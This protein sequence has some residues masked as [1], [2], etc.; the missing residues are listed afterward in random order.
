MSE[1]TTIDDIAR[2][3]NISKT[4]VSRAI[5]GKGRIG[6]ATRERVLAYIEEHNYRPSAIAKSLASSKT[7]NLAFAMPAASDFVDLPFFQKCMWGIS[8]TASEA[9]YDVLLCMVNESDISG[10]ERLASNHKVDGVILGRTYENGLA[11]QF[12]TE[13]GIPFVT[14][15]MSAFEGAVQVDNHHRKGCRELT[16]YLIKSG[17]NKIALI[18]GHEG[19]MVDRNRCRGFKDAF[20]MNGRPFRDDLFFNYVCEGKSV[21]KTVGAILDTDCECIVCMDD[22][23]CNLVVKSLA[24]RGASVPG[25]I[26]LASFYNSPVLSGGRPAV[27]ALDFDAEAIGR[28]SC[29]ILLDCIDGREV[30]PCTLLGYEMLIRESTCS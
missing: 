10:L 26:G 11:E 5:S 17:Y 6:A 23:V 1:R 3:L 27:T 9:D 30:S 2:D 12:L 28:E 7:F 4:T 16:E 22:A 29:R 24:A 21:E 8:S 18:G 14:I 19:S 13:R 15:G 20:T 25:R